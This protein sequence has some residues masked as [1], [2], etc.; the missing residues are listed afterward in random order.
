MNRLRQM[1]V[2]AEVFAGQELGGKQDLT[3]VFREVLNY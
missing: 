2:V 3:S 1:P